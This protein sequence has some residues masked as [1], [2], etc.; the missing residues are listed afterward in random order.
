MLD[1]GDEISD[2]DIAALY[3]DSNVKSKLTSS[4]N[5]S[6]ENQEIES[7]DDIE[8]SIDFDSDSSLDASQDSFDDGDGDMSN[9]ED[10]YAKYNFGNKSEDK[11]KFKKSV[12]ISKFDKGNL[13]E[14]YL[15]AERR[16]KKEELEEKKR[17]IIQGTNF[18]NSLRK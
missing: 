1:D 16:R 12:D 9:L 13:S 14:E 18:D 5:A 4:S 10:K 7:F 17:R 15:E 2:E 8:N 3:S 11:P 6:T